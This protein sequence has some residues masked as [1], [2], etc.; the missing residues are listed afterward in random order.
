MVD[1]DAES[2][3][4]EERQTDIVYA[5]P[6]STGTDHSPKRGWTFAGPDTNLV[7]LYT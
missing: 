2:S 1:E 3:S 5:G 7:I 4:Q 6:L